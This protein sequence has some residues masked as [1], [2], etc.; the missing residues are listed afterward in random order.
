[1]LIWH[2]QSSRPEI[3]TTKELLASLSLPRSQDK[4][5]ESQRAVVQTPRNAIR[6]GPILARLR[7]SDNYEGTLFSFFFSIWV[8]I[9][10][11][12]EYSSILG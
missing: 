9:L 6:L 2:W 8:L 4:E 10:G 11:C 12:P 1:M 5:E 3:M 7:Q